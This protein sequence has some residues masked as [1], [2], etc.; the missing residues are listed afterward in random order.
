MAGYEPPV[1]VAPPQTGAWPAYGQPYG[2]PYGQPPAYGTGYWPAP[3]P[4]PRRSA[5][6]LIAVVVVVVMA[7]LCAGVAV[8][9]GTYRIA[10]GSSDP[11]SVARGIAPPA[12][13]TQPVPSASAP[14]V[15]VS[16]IAATVDPSVVDIVS[17]LGLQRASAAGT[18][19]VLT[20]SG[21]VL[22][23]NHVING[24]TSISVTDVGNGQT[25]QAAVVGYDRSQDLAVI[26]LQNAYNLATAPLGDSS[27]VAIGD[28]IVAIGNAGGKGGTPSAVP[29]SVTAI[30]QSITASDEGGGNE[31]QLNG[32]IQV[33]AQVVPGDS[34]GP[35]ANTGAQVIGIDTAASSGNHVQSSAGE[36]FAIPINQALSIARQ[37]VAGQAS[38]KIHIGP[39]GFLGI[40]GNPAPSGQSGVVIT[41]VAPG[42]PAATAG[43][44]AGDRIVSIDGTT[45]DSPATLSNLLVPHH[46]GD[47]LSIG[48]VRQSGRQAS[49]SIQLGT[50]PAA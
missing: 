34:G 45:V 48:V 8:A 15:D 13:V 38:S 9:W 26:Q 37:I 14:N 17:T 47:R 29:G 11:T 46:P 20:S 36:G 28:G 19:I 27:K 50:G 32:L 42:S 16:G 3:P 10:S 33:A 18:G 5:G 22:T 12:P 2:E 6:P 21:E 30:D 49:I 7:L 35:L 40:S 41:Q 24:A 23:N 25:Y 39:T 1:R 44:V 4:P 43:L 31:Q